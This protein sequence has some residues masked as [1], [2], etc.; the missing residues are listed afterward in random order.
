MYIIV[1]NEIY[2]LDIFLLTLL[3]T[4]KSKHVC[5]KHSHRGNANIRKEY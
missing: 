2:N 5:K 4:K 1:L 3:P